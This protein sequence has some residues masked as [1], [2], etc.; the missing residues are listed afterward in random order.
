VLDPM[1]APTDPSLAPTAVNLADL[2]R[3]YT[4]RMHDSMPS[5]SDSGWRLWKLLEAL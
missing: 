1:T 5:G 2:Y 3:R 4:R